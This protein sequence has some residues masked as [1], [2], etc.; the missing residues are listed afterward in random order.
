MKK[1]VLHVSAGGLSHGGVGSVIFSIVQPL[2][3]QYDFGCVVFARQYD[4]ELLFEKYG[5]LYRINCYPT[6]GKRNYFELITRPFKLYFGI[7]KLCK[8]H[9]FDIIHCHN[10]S[11]AWP[12]L[13]AAKHARVPVRISHAHVGRSLKKKSAF[14][15]L[16]KSF[17]LK[18]L[19]KSATDRVACSKEAGESLFGNK[20]FDVIYNAINLQR[21]YAEPN[22]NTEGTVNFIHVGR[23]NYAKNQ[24][25][26]I[27]TF[28]EISNLMGNVHLFLVGYGTEEDTLRYKKMIRDFD[29]DDK[30]DMVPGDVVD[31]A[32]FYKKAEYMLFPSRFEGFPV[33]LVE[34]QAAGLSCYVS[35]RI[36]QEINCGALTYLNL[37]DG[38][39]KWAEVIVADIKSGNK[40]TC[41]K[42]LLLR[43]GEEEICKQYAA[44]YNG[45][46][47]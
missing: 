34:A 40:K 13:L 6:K 41:N 22:N 37:S 18:L 27:E 5:K 15:K 21:F 35:E 24:E 14:E 38:A 1:S 25:F 19:L 46:K 26:V 11:D 4:R 2:Y 45:E 32:E 31:V 44:L 12:C 8:K 23:F 33:T 42:E 29:L 30:V 36:L 7:R 28:K 39:K 20:S 9:N 47:L 16:Y 10:Q 3:E 17:C 43:F